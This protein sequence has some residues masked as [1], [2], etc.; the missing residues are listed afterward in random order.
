MTANSSSLRPRFEDVY[1][2]FISRAGFFESDDYYEQERE[3]YWQTLN[4]LKS[5]PLPDGARILEIGGGQLAILLRKLF[6]DDCM[7]ADI[8]AR[9]RAPI[10]RAGVGFIEYDLMK[11][12]PAE[13]KEGFDVV[14]LLEVIEHIPV[15]GHI[16]FSKLSALLKENGILF[17]TT[18]NLHRPRNLIRM[19]LGREFFGPF[20]IAEPGTALGH[21]LEYSAMHL[22]WQLERAGLVVVMLKYDQLGVRGHSRKA[23]LVRK[24]LTPLQIRPIWREG[25]VAAAQKMPD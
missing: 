22:R 21:Q 2:K 11:D 9:Y 24:I 19:F 15:P 7:V 13:L 8:S 16:V 1:G 18:P 23:R 14:V 3:R 4:L 20:T 10:D 12:A 6:N 5:L 25:L 17:L